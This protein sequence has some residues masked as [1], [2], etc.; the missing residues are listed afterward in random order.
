MSYICVTA[1]VFQ[2][3]I[4]EKSRKNISKYD[5]DSGIQILILAT[6]IPLLSV[7]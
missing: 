2:G 7:N 4:Y 1:H 5:R 3:I 6:S